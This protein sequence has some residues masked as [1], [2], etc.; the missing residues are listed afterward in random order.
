MDVFS[1]ISGITLI[2]VVLQSEYRTSFSSIKERF[3]RAR[4]EIRR[5]GIIG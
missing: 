1:V 4:M 3:T 2:R 5:W